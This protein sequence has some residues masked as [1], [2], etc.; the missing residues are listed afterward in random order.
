MLTNPMRHQAGR[1]VIAL[2]IA[3]AFALQAML[4]AVVGTQHAVAVAIDAGF[5][6]ICSGLATAPQDDGGVSPAS[7]QQ[8][9]VTCAATCLPA[10]LPPPALAF[11][12]VLTTPEPAARRPGARPVAPARFEIP[13]HA[14]GP[15]LAA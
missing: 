15:P 5:T 6:V 7:V 3:Y 10:A 8:T 9:C 4:V 1:S 14:Q 11:S 12:L 13:R 2:V